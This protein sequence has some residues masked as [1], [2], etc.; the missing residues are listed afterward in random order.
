MGASQIGITE[1]DP[2]QLEA[3]RQIG[4]A[5]FILRVAYR[6]LGLAASAMFSQHAYGPQLGRSLHSRT[7]AFSAQMSVFAKIDYTATGPLNPPIAGTMG[8]PWMSADVS[9]KPDMGFTFFVLC[10]CAVAVVLGL[11]NLS[12][13]H[14]RV[15]PTTACAGSACYLANRLWAES[16]I[17]C[18]SISRRRSPRVCATLL[19]KATWDVT[20]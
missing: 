9:G 18:S 1:Q 16:P 14:H 20:T 8:S 15:A 12:T 3:R 6:N 17:A 10:F 5:A 7:R 13:G 4:N 19:F 2:T 11:I